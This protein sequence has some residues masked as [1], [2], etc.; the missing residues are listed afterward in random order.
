MIVVKSPHNLSAVPGDSLKWFVIEWGGFR[1]YA[2]SMPGPR[3]ARTTIYRAPYISLDSDEWRPVIPRR[4]FVCL[5]LRWL[6]M[7]G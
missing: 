7:L 4:A 6:Q 3:P 5:R 2:Q 1:D